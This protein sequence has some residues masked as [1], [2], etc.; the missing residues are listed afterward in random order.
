MNKTRLGLGS[1][2]PHSSRGPRKQLR[3]FLRTRTIPRSSLRTFQPSGSS[4]L[5]ELLAR[6]HRARVI[7][8]KT[9]PCPAH[10]KLQG[11]PRRHQ[12]LFWEVVFGVRG[13]LTTC[14]LRRFDFTAARVGQ[15]HGCRSIFQAGWLCAP[16]FAIPFRTRQYCLPRFGDVLSRSASLELVRQLAAC[17]HPFVCAH[18]RPSVVPLCVVGEH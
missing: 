2:C 7:G 18:G 15:R 5:L 8:G 3:D 6:K 12:V 13:A 4:G 1:F 14:A 16:N 17:A 11:V 9:P 10:T